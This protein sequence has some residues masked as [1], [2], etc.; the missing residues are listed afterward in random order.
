MDRTK[1]GTV[2]QLRL[3]SRPWKVKEGPGVSSAIPVSGSMSHQSIKLGKTLS[4][5]LDSAGRG[6]STVP[7]QHSGLKPCFLPSLSESDKLKT[8]LWSGNGR[9]FSK[10]QVFLE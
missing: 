9:P 7:D 10:K 8:Q 4:T 3:S 1:V 6:R 2:E 5:L